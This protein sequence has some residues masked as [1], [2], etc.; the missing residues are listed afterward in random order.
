MVSPCQIQNNQWIIVIKT[1]TKVFHYCL[2]CR[3]AGWRCK[4]YFEPKTLKISSPAWSKLENSS[5][6][7]RSACSDLM[8]ALFHVCQHLRDR[9]VAMWK[10]AEEQESHITVRQK[11]KH[12]LG[13]QIKEFNCK[14]PSTFTADEVVLFT[15]VQN[16]KIFLGESWLSLPSTD[17]LQGYNSPVYRFARFM[18][19]FHTFLR[20]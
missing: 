5:A 7:P 13:F 12:C 8:T 3:A 10:H 18:R 16:L 14:H 17:F 2:R 15:N 6:R 1:K 9:C 20:L 4:K 11:K 19:H